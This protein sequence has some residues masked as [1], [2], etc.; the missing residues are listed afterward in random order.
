MKNYNIF[1]K[2]TDPKERKMALLTW[3]LWHGIVII[4]CFPVLCFQNF[5]LFYTFVIQIYLVT[6]LQ[7]EALSYELLR[8]FFLGRCTE[9]SYIPQSLQVTSLSMRTPYNCPYCRQTSMRRGNVDVHVQRKH[10]HNYNPYPDMKLKPSDCNFSRPKKIQPPNFSSPQYES[11]NIRSPRY[12]LSDSVQ[13]FQDLSK[14]QNVLQE[15]S[16]WN[17]I[18]LNYLIIAINNLPNFRNYSNSLF[19]YEFPTYMSFIRRSGSRT[20][21]FLDFT[22][23]SLADLPCHMWISNLI[24]FSEHEWF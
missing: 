9:N 10:P 24:G 7:E 19:W 3:C 15:I 12:N 14:F 22:R 6:I 16:Q 18:Q 21:G 20:R 2:D 8:C 4:R 13:F 1:T 5:H 23:A 11:S 17:K